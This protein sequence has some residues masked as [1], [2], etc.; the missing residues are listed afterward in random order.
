LH[1][2]SFEISHIPWFHAGPT[3]QLVSPAQTMISPMKQRDHITLFMPGWDDDEMHQCLAKVY[4][5]AMDDF[6][7]IEI[8]ELAFPLPTHKSKFFGNIPRYILMTDAQQVCFDNIVV[9]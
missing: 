1:L 2:T 5:T 9:K 7:V 8:K 4:T 6:G 3:V